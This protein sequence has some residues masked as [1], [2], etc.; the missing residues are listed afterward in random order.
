MNSTMY[1]GAGS[2]RDNELRGGCRLNVRTFNTG[3][4]RERAVIPLGLSKEIRHADLVD[5]D[6]VSLTQGKLVPLDPSLE[7]AGIIEGVG[8]ERGAYVATVTTRGAIHVKVTGLSPET[9]E[10]SKVYALP[11]TRTVFTLEEQGALIGEVCAIENV[12]R[13]MAIVGVRVASDTRRFELGGPRPSR[14]G[15]KTRRIAFTI[16][17]REGQTM[18]TNLSRTA[19]LEML[20]EGTQRLDA[21]VWNDREIRKIPTEDLARHAYQSSVSLHKQY[22]GEEMFVAHWAG[23][24]RQWGLAV[25]SNTYP[26]DQRIREEWDRTPAVRDEFKGNFDTYAALVRATAKGGVRIVNATV[27]GGGPL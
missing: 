13:G 5:G 18:S 17:E 4:A 12:E 2:E 24:R 22:L 27:Q 10:G 1:S 26:L 6:L 19:T 20:L 25:P 9:R 15:S 7:F 16:Y 3:L 14:A 11:G 23:Q 21:H 8:E